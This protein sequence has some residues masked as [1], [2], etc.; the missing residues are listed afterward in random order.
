MQNPSGASRRLALVS[1]A[2]AVV[3]SVLAL[4]VWWRV[5]T[6]ALSQNA[7]A[8][9]PNAVADMF[10][11]DPAQFAG[12]PPEK[13]ALLEG[14]YLRAVQG[15]RSPPPKNPAA[16]P[17]TPAPTP[18]GGPITVPQRPAGAGI[19]V[20]SGLAP[21]PGSVYKIENSWHKSEGNG[22]IQVFAG[23]EREDPAQG[24]V[25]VVVA[26]GNG[27]PSPPV[28]VYRTP[29]KAG[30]VRVVEAEGER[31]TLRT[32]SGATFIFDVPTRRFLSP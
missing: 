5:G 18:A 16:P 30:A 7:P 10:G 11:I 2:G 12:L 3:A 19:I 21:L 27:Q 24:V 13:R 6:L 22:F 23:A 15:R 26:P 14:S 20:E 29:T 17:P 8:A 25:A 9:Q 31:L 32:S 4:M 1:I 28:E